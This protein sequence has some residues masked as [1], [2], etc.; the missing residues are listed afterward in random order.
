MPS[1]QVHVTS[2]AMTSPEDM[3]FKRETLGSSKAQTNGGKFFYCQKIDGFCIEKKVTWYPREVSKYRSWNDLLWIHCG[4]QDVFKFGR[5]NR[6][7]AEV[8]KRPSY[9]RAGCVKNSTARHTI[10][11]VGVSFGICKSMFSRNF[12][13]FCGDE[14]KKCY[15][16]CVCVFSWIYQHSI[17]MFDRVSTTEWCITMKKIDLGHVVT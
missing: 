12:V 8:L 13:D 14:V 15:P 1:S 3:V 17:S 16:N 9:I 6:W 10:P 11:V 2:S 7:W 4:F 5:S